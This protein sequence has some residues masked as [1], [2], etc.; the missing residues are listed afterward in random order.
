MLRKDKKN[1][2][3]NDTLYKNENKPLENQH[4]KCST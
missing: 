1:F 2:L 3:Y 4:V